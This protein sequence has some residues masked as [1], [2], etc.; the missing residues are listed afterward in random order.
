MDILNAKDIAQIERLMSQY[1][2]QIKSKMI[3]YK[4]WAT[5]KTW[6]SISPFVYV[7]SSSIEAG[8]RSPLYI[9]VFTQ[10]TGRKRG[11]VPYR[12]WEIIEQW[13]IDK[14]LS[15][16]TSKDRERFSRAVA[17]KIAKEG[18]SQFRSGKNTD[19]FTDQK[20]LYER[21]FVQIVKRAASNRIREILGY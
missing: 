12:F 21:K 10:E 6:N 7:S 16:R 13:S 19:I 15:F 14:G 5:G 8:L 18:T 9:S 4:K 20:P 11:R 17:F 2:L 3:M 1:K